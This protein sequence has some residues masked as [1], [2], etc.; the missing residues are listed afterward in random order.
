MISFRKFF[1][2]GMVDRDIILLVLDSFM[3]KL[4]YA[5]LDA[6]NEYG[7]DDEYESKNAA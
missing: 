3:L 2:S 4:H 6:A 5:V 7:D 1:E